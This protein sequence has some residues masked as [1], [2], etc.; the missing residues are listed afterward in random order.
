MVLQKSGVCLCL[1]LG[2]APL[3]ELPRPG[4]LHSLPVDFE[5]ERQLA[6]GIEIRRVVRAVDAD[7]GDLVGG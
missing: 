1:Q 4:H 3:G 6:A 2:S 5:V 7:H